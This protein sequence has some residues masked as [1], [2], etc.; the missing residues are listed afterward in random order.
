M[1]DTQKI[2]IETC[3]HITGFAAG[4]GYQGEPPACSYLTHDK[5]PIATIKFAYCPL[6]G[7]SLVK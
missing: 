4:W 1:K 3:K 7:V 6:C 2:K 5:N